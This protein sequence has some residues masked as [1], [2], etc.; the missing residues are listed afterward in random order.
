MPDPALVG[1]EADAFKY[2]NVFRIV[3]STQDLICA[4]ARLLQNQGRGIN[5]SLA[6]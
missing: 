2:A 1:G 5:Q 4:S 6:F 3:L